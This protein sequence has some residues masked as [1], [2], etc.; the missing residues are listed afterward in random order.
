M[1]LRSLATTLPTPI[2]AALRLLVVD[3]NVELAENVAEVFEDAGCACDVV[4]TAEGACAKMREHS[5]DG[6]LTDFR[7]PGMSGLQLIREVRRTGDD[8][9]LVML[10]GFADDSVVRSAREAGALAVLA[11]PLNMEKLV[12]IVDTLS[13]RGTDVLVV[14]DDPS[15]ADN[16][17]EIVR[18]S[19]RSAIVV[20]DAKSALD[21]MR[22]PGAAIVDA[23][24]AGESGVDVAR[25][26][27]ARDPRVRVVI[28]TGYADEV[29]RELEAR[30]LPG[31]D[32][33]DA[34]LEKPCDVELL[35]ARLRGHG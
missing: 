20:N 30:E 3:D 6:V 16:L 11:K 24:L 8:T 4:D 34:L 12:G 7:L 27:K 13:D 14:D 22:L 29:R 9:P 26:L 23:R 5:Y 10:S 32:A 31:F 33:G 1:R 19:G 2:V 18:D 17:A 21:A 28:V 25:Q 15:L 35:K